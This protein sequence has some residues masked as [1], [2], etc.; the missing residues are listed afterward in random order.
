MMMMM[1]SVCNYTCVTHKEVLVWSSQIRVRNLT[2]QASEDLQTRDNRV[3]TTEKQ[4]GKNEM[5]L[6]KLGTG[7]GLYGEV[8]L[9]ELLII[10]AF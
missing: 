9:T 8:N 1:M 10:N 2:P 6:R 7:V 5:D 3:L 4:Q